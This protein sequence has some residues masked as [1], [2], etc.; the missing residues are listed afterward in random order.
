MWAFS[1]GPRLAVARAGAA[2][3]LKKGAA[4]IATAEIERDNAEILDRLSAFLSERPDAIDGGMVSELRAACGLS[5]EE[6]YRLLLASLCGLDV[7]ERA[8]DR[9]LY[10]NYFPRMARRL[11]ADAYRRDPYYQN[12]ALP[13]ARAGRWQLQRERYRP[14]QA[15]VA[16]DLRALPDGRIVPRIG[17]FEEEFSFPAVLEGGREWMLISPNEIETMRPAVR[18]A[19]GRVLAYGL[20]LGYFP[21]LASLKEEVASITVVER[22]PSAIELF[23]RYIKAQFARA[24]KLEIVLDDAFAFA[25]KRLARGRYDVVFADLWH[26]PADGVPIYLRMKQFEALSP[27]SEYV[28]WIEETLKCYL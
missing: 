13:E 12:I 14:Y 7:A 4:F 22:D 23:D 15:F 17:F 24:D 21:Y 2:R 11:D 28:Y 16:G 9:A 18:A 19:R 6:A 25:Q 26:D 27:Q 3:K 8:R 20:G 5:A 10:Q 1:V